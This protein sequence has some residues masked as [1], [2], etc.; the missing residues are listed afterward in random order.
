MQ[1]VSHGITL[2][3]KE[4]PLIE[5]E[6]TMKIQSLPNTKVINH[7]VATNE[8]INNKNCE[9]ATVISGTAGFEAALLGKKVIQFS[10]TYL[11]LLPNV[12]VLT[13]LSRFTEVYKKIGNFDKEKTILMLAKLYENSF[14]EHYDRFKILKIRSHILT[15]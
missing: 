1:L 15:Q 9:L 8:I 10:D 2:A 12:S 11:K 5:E 4:H 3:V 14:E 13:D 6:N 7:N